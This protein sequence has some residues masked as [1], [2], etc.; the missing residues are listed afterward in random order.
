[1]RANL[2]VHDARTFFDH[3]I[4]SVSLSVC[5]S[6]SC[7]GV[8]GIVGGV[9]G[10]IVAK[11]A[12]RGVPSPALKTARDNPGSLMEEGSARARI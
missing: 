7:C 1:M 11:H 5:I 4:E 12:T 9:R 8:D 3:K 2:A 6:V 10:Y